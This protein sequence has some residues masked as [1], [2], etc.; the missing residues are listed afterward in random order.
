MNKGLTV[1]ELLA[2]CKEQVKAGNGNKH[3]QISA[4]DEGNGFHTLFLG[5]TDDA[6]IIKDYEEGGYFHD[7]VDADEIVILG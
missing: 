2:L 4:D 1:R 5:F 6:Q 3:V 7:E